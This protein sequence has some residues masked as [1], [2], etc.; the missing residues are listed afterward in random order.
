[1]RSIPQGIAGAIIVALLA[2]IAPAAAGIPQVGAP[3]PA[4][5]IPAIANASGDLTLSRYAGK[6]IYLNF[7]ASWCEPCKAEVPS[8]VQLSKEYA[9]RGVVVI[10]I[11]ELESASAADGFVARFKLPYPIG[12][13]D[14]GSVGGS[15]GLI[16][17][18][19]HVFIG[20]DGKL[21]LRRAGEMSADQ[22]RAALD[23]I[24]RR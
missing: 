22:I 10:G 13:D 1:V 17:M 5:S 9:K 11:D 8:I 15:Y 19:M 3:A 20:A 2:T 24:A 21:V 14:S 12:L 6:A 18:P 16:G 7:F 23:Q 4:F